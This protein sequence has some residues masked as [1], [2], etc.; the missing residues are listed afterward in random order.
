MLSLLKK[1]SNETEK[2]EKNSQEIED[3]VGG[4]EQNRGVI[5]ERCNLAPESEVVRLE[6]IEK[7]EAKEPDRD[8]VQENVA[9]NSHQANA[10]TDAGAI[11]GPPAMDPL[12][13]CQM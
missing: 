1:L 3:A 6:C 4:Y 12:V 8:N 10:V 13:L 9:D 7:L 2:Y 11:R 5:D